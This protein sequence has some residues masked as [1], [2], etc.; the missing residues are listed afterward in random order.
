[1][2]IC[3]DFVMLNYPKTGSSF[4][5]KVIK[6]IFKRRSS[7]N[8]LKKLAYEINISRPYK[9]LILPNF[10]DP[11]PRIRHLVGQHGAYC[12]VPKEYI[13]RTIVSVIRNPYERFLSG[14]LYRWW[15][16]NPSLSQ[17]ELDEHFPNFPNL[18]LD[19]Y[20]KYQQLSSE[21]S[22]LDLGSQTIQFIRM[23]FKDPKRVLYNITEDYIKSDSAYQQDM[24]KILFLKQE[25][26]NNELSNFLSTKEFSREEVE[27]A[28]NYEKTN[29]TKDRGQD[30]NSIW[31]KEA[32]EHLERSE[33]LLFTIL[34]NIGYDC[35]RPESNPSI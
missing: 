25:N 33:Q 35:K 28:K 32:I 15:A 16:D 19:D 14:Y 30:K 24:P 2:I 5:R 11:N 26:L 18:N 27:F 4:V 31:T 22:E 23:F 12:Q 10:Q 13:D 9:E 6:D 8:L 7:D 20:I 17:D 21:D 1:M 34:K 29:V 3:N